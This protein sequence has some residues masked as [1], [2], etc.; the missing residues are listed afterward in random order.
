MMQ[1]CNEGDWRETIRCFTMCMVWGEGIARNRIA[2]F[3]R[4]VCGG[5]GRRSRSHMSNTRSRTVMR[6]SNRG[7]NSG[8]RVLILL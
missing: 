6:L 1:M 5:Q 3:L 8:K 4:G 7:R 2:A